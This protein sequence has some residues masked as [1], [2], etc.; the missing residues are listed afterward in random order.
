MP[1]GWKQADDIA[2]AFWRKI[3]R[4]PPSF[5]VVDGSQGKGPNKGKWKGQ[6]IV[7]PSAEK[8]GQRDRRWH[9]RGTQSDTSVVPQDSR[10]KSADVLAADNLAQIDRLERAIAVLGED[11]VDA[12]SLIATLK[13]V[14]A[15]SIEPIGDRLDAC[16]QFV[17]KSRKRAGSKVCRGCSVCGRKQPHNPGPR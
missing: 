10:R 13:K 2:Q 5:S 4:G 15:K 14:R 11:S 1:R 9:A 6:R 3:L 12:A 7:A 17:E 16:Q 8:R